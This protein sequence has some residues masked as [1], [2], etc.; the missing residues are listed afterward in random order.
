MLKRIAAVI[1]FLLPLELYAQVGPGPVP[2]R[3]VNNWNLI[4]GTDNTYDIGASGATRP[5][6]G[7][8]GTS[9]VTPALTVS[10]LTSGRVPFAS[11]GGLFTDDAAFTF[12]SGTGAVS[13]TRILVGAG[14]AGSP[15]LAFA[16]DDDGTGSGFHRNAANQ[17]SVDLDGTLRYYFTG[18]AF[19][20]NSAGSLDLGSSITVAMW[21]QLWLGAAIQGATVK[22]LAEGTPTEFVRVAVPQTAG[23][24]FA[25][26]TAVYTIYATDGTETQAIHG[27][28]KFSAVNKAGTETCA[29]IVDSQT[30]A[31]VSAG[32][33][34]CTI[35]CVTGL[36]NLIGLAADCT[37]SL[38]QTTLSASWRLDMP[39]A[40]TVTAQ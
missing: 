1:L 24:N 8:F 34:T 4:F 40:N 10:G 25:A 11:T 20:P 12:A 33:L 7:Y 3:G 27:E 28:A 35:T 16:A 5:R 21:R 31:A 9:V 19:N 14:T 32:T 15:A 29:A 18:S 23:S 17:I 30:L 26:G 38:T 22:N 37:S 6:T 36:T 13:T 39:R 2:Y